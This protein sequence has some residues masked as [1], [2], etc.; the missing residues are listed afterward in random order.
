M[1]QQ[2]RLPPRR[3]QYSG[4]DPNRLL[5]VGP[6]LDGVVRIRDRAAFVWPVHCWRRQTQ[7]NQLY[8]VWSIWVDQFYWPAKR[9]VR[10]Q[11]RL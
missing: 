4:I 6:S 7:R 2:E 3:T 11:F 9:L 1:Q 5:F 10:R 8:S